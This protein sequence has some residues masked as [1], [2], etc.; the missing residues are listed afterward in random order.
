MSTKYAPSIVWAN[1]DYYTGS[2]SIKGNVVPSVSY[3]RDRVAQRLIAVN[4]FPEQQKGDVVTPVTSPYQKKF[5]TED[6]NNQRYLKYVATLTTT[7]DVNM[8]TVEA[9]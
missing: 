7:T 5:P 2:Y 3:T 4:F 1:D 9:M 6:I 8:A